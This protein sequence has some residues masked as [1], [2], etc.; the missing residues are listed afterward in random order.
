MKITVI[1]AGV[2]GL[3]CAHEL[4]EAGHEVTVVADR[5]P[6]DTVSAR[7][8]AVWFPYR[9]AVPSGEDATRLTERSLLRFV[10]LADSAAAAVADGADDITDDIA[11]VE[12]R[13][14]TVIE[15]RGT[16]DRSWVPAVT[17]VLGTDAVR[18]TAG[19]VETTLPMIMMPTYL[20]WLMDSC[21][22]AGVQFRWRKVESLAALYDGEYATAAPDVVVVAGGLRGGE[23]LGGDEEVTPVRGQIVVLANGTGTDGSPEPLTDWITDDDNPDGETYVLPRVDDIVVGGTAEPG[24]WDETPDPETAR[25][26]LA[27]AVALVPELE[28]LPVLGHGTGL[29]PGRTT[30]RLEVV[31]PATLP[32]NAA[33]AAGVPVIAAYG[34][35]GAGVTLSWGTAE[36][37]AE[38]VAG[39]AAGTAGGETVTCSAP[40]VG[41]VAEGVQQQGDVQV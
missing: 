9:T 32:D 15:R 14:G 29:R 2:T 38:L 21:R 1:G 33:P 16:P 41:G 36:R 12:M 27:R 37:V 7:A 28:G 39:L 11:P 6:G 40:A 30:I 22:V 18:P 35:G 10:E 3:S 23:L 8:A 31:D 13:R 25:A 20:A 17:A 24:V 4:A 26:I 5:G 19:G 34:H